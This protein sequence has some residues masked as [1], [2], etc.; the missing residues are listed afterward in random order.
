GSLDNTIRL[1]DAATGTHQ[2]TL[3][4]HSGYVYTVAFSPDGKTL[5]SG[6]EDNTIRL[7][8]AATGTHQQTLEGHSGSVWAVAFSPDGKTLASGSDD[9]TIRLWDAATGTHQ[10]TLK[11]HSNDITRQSDYV[12][13][14]AFSPDGKSG[15][16]A[17]RN[18]R[19]VGDIL[20]VDGEWI[21]RGE[22]NL[23]WLPRDYRPRCTTVYGNTLVLGH[24]SGQ[25]TFLQINTAQ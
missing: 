6:S 19:A 9:D 15:L 21:I 7:W 18:R 4:G 8:D 22:M 24:K 12:R 11:G 25:I 14:I 1:W 20:F 17:S 5:A 16:D 2:Q 3:E 23:L 13:V 10:Q